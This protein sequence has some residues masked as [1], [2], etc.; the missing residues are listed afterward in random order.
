MLDHLVI[1][2]K[3]IEKCHTDTGIPR[4]YPRPWRVEFGSRILYPGEYGSGSGSKFHYKST[5][6]GPENILI[7]LTMIAARPFS[8][9]AIDSLAIGL[10]RRLGW[11]LIVRPPRD[12]NPRRFDGFIALPAF[13]LDIE[14]LEESSD[15]EE[16]LE[17][18]MMPY[19]AQ[20]MKVVSNGE[21]DEM[22]RKRSEN[23]K[24]EPDDTKE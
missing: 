13:F 14:D 20:V 18:C 5:G 21:N 19:F 1:A 9:G 8:Y 11:C 7:V 6:L 16:L 4:P 2:G 10:H 17:V 24:N 22:E 3:K 12:S 23:D 15:E